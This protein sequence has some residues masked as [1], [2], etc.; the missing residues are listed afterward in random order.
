MKRGLLI[1]IIIVAILIVVFGVYAFFQIATQG[2]LTCAKAGY[3]SSNPSLGPSDPNN[4]CCEGLV[5]ISNDLRYEPGAEYADEDG[6]AMTEG[7]GSICSDCGN[8]NCEDWEN[9]C[10]CPVDCPK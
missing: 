8:G 4:Q 1:G 9:P 3:T 5:S 6:C 7:G 2:S 10:N